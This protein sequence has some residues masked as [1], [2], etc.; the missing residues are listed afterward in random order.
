MRDSENHEPRFEDAEIEDLQRRVTSAV[1]RN[2][3]TWLRERAEDIAQD[4]LVKLVRSKR[5]ADGDKTFSPAYVEK[6]V[7]GAVVDEIRR[8][9]RRRE[10]PVADPASTERI[11]SGH[12]P[13]RHDPASWEVA[14][15]LVDC[16][17]K[18]VRSRRLAVTLYLNGCT[19]REAATR[20]H[21]GLHK[22]ENLVYR[23]LAD[24]RVCLER[25][26]LKP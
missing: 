7:S 21:W 5:K 18:L 3:P 16:L 22:T 26:G 25:K 23:G 4:V 12:A 15:G 1:R 20:L 8:A 19:V 14:G 2:C 11:A 24:L 17:G 6:A 10:D 13:S 9:C